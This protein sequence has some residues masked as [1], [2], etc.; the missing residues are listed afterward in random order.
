MSK[1]DLS[2]TSEDWAKLVLQ[3][4]GTRNTAINCAQRIAIIRFK[5]GT[6]R[7]GPGFGWS[8]H[9]RQWA[10]CKCFGTR[11]KRA[12]MSSAGKSHSQTQYG[13]APG[14]NSHSVPTPNQS[15]EDRLQRHYPHQGQNSSQL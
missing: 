7:L 2:S 14:S 6:L 8:S 11:Q 4:N 3:N 12:S 1:F 13:F 15:H 9:G 10:S 5:T